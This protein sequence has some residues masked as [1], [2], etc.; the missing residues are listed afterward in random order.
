M[1]PN[2]PVNR[3]MTEPVL[4]IEADESVEQ[5]MQLFTSYPVHHL[6]VV[7]AGRVVGML[8][9]ADVAKL[10][11]FLPPPGNARSAL[12]HYR[13]QV[14]KIMQSPAITVGEHE[15]AQRAAELMATHGIHSLPVVNCR[16]ALIGIVTTTDIMHGCLSPPRSAATFDAAD[17]CR[18]RALETVLSAAKRY[19]N[20]GQDERLH[21]ALQKA[22]DQAELSTQGMG[23]SA[24]AF[25]SV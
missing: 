17:P 13:W 7:E 19:L 5:A 8:S 24:S 16:G 25:S 22:I 14:R 1:H 21:T 6:P 15:S 23:C 12:L 3:I 10:R 2:D 9:S 18:V 20:A 4:T 11:F